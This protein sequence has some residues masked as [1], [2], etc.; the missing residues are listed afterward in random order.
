M[1]KPS[2]WAIDFNTLD[3]TWVCWP[4]TCWWCHP[5]SG[6]ERFGERLWCQATRLSITYNAAQHVDSGAPGLW[7]LLIAHLFQNLPMPASGLTRTS[8]S[9]PSQ[10][11]PHRNQW[12]P[13][14]LSHGLGSPRRSTSWP[15]CMSWKQKFQE[16]L[17]V[18]PSFWYLRPTDLE[19]L[20]LGCENH[21]AQWFYPQWVL[22]I[23]WLHLGCLAWHE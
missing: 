7:T 14:S 10:C 22:L 21:T 2:N 11:S 12:Q 20:S 5:W 13:Q 16:G 8:S 23:L 3:F 6:M 9:R 18:P 4:R 19:R 15:T 17:L 1:Q